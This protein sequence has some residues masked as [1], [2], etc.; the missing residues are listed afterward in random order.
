MSAI[1]KEIRVSI[2]DTGNTPS[3]RI[4]NIKQSALTLHAGKKYHFKQSLEEHAKHPFGISHSREK[5]FTKNNIEPPYNYIIGQT[6][7]TLEIT[8]ASKSPPLYYHS[9][10]K[11]HMGANINIL[12]SGKGF[13]GKN[14]GG[15]GTG[16]S[17]GSCASCG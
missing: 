10:N 8:V 15:T 17:T 1:F 6:D 7:V 12:K 4:D 2:D 14:K 3:Y 16:M 11:L 9:N 13:G 5:I